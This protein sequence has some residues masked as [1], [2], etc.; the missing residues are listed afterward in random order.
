MGGVSAADAEAE[1]NADPEKAQHFR[2]AKIGF[3]DVR[4]LQRYK[5]CVYV[6]MYVC[7]FGK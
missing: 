4:L 5:V 3:D 6:C 1:K 2:N 7:V